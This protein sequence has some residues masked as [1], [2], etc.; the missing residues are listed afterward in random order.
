M[1]CAGD[2]KRIENTKMGLKRNRGFTSSLSLLVSSLL[3]IATITPSTLV[4]TTAWADNFFGTSAPDTINGTDIE[5]NIFGEG[6]DDNLNG[7]GGDDYVEGHAGND[8]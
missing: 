1:I 8:E 7:E 6:G 4:I 2:E 5:D 3:L